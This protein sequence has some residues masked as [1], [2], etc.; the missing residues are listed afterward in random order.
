MACRGIDSGNGNWNIC[1]IKCIEWEKRFKIDLL[2][3]WAYDEKVV[4]IT[5]IS[6]HSNVC[7]L[8][9]NFTHI[10]GC[11]YHFNLCDWKNRTGKHR[12][13]GD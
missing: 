10:L 7:I 5:G 4:H 13:I 6:V 3:D 9:G 1:D 2:N 11:S 12:R 8:P